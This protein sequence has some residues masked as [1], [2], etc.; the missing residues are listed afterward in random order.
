MTSLGL[1]LA[2]IRELD[3]QAHAG[4]AGTTAGAV[5]PAEFPACMPSDSNLGHALALTRQLLAETDDTRIEAPAQ[6]VATI[7]AQRGRRSA[8]RAAAV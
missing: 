3:G 2:F 4:G 7:A 5:P 1:V 8:A 6:T